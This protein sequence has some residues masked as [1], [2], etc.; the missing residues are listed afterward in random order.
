MAK[1]SIALLLMCLGALF[2]AP[3]LAQADTGNIIE[4]NTE[5][6]NAAN[7][8][9][10]ATCKTDEPV[11]GEPKIHCSPQT[12]GAFYTLA[13]GH[14]PIGFTQYIIKHKLGEGKVEPA[15]IPVPTAEIEDPA[16]DQSIKTLR[17]DLPPGLT[18]NPNATPKCSLAE[19]ENKV[20]EFHVPTCKEGTIV[21]R[22]EI[23][24]VTTVAGVPAPSPPF[25]A[26]NTLPKGFIIPP[27]ESSGTKVPVYNLQPKPG[28]PALFGFVA[29]G[30]EVVFLETEVSWQNDFHES[31]TINLPK[32]EP[33]FATLISRLVNFGQEAGDK[34]LVE[35]GNGTYINNPTTCFD[36]N[37]FPTLYSTWFRAHSYGEE[38]P[39]FPFGSTPFEA[40]VESSTGELIQQ[41]GCETVPFEPGIEV[42]PGTKEIDSPAGPTV[43][44]TLEYLTGEESEQQESHLRK[45]AET[46]PAGMGLNPS[47]AQGLKAC[48]DAQFKKGVRTYTNE[49]PAESKIGTV[50]IESP[51][52]E[53]PLEGDVY[54]GEQKSN[55]PQSGEE[56]RILVEAKEE[57]EG[58][59]VRLVG[60]TKANPS[61]G[62]LTAVFN[63][64]QVGE[65]AGKLPEGL[66]QVP[67][68]SVRIH[69]DQ[70]KAVLTSPPTCSPATTTGEMTPWARPEEVVKISSEPFT[71]STDPN[72]G[73]CPKT[74]AER[75]FAPSYKAN[76]DSAKGGSFSPF[77]VRIARTDGQQELKV[78]N[79][80]LPKGLTGKLAGI[81]Y[82]AEA[83]ITAAAANSGAAEKAKPS[84][85][86]ESRLGSV[87]TVS[88]TGANPLHLTGQAYLAGPYKGAPISLVTVTPAVAGPFDLGTVVVRVALNVNPETAQVNAVSDVIPDVFGGVK[89]DL[90]S[91]NLDID[92][93]Q[94]MVNPTNCAAQATTGAING[95]GADPTNPAVFS[96]YAVNDPFQATECNKLGFKPKLK[97]Q[98]FGPTTRAKNPRLKAVLTARGG[99]ANIVRTA[100]TTPH[101]LFLD[102]RHIGTVCT[103]PQLASHTCPAASVYGTA[104][105]KSPLLSG[106]LKGKVYLV[107]SNHKL[108][109]L[110]A[111]LRGQVEIYLRA[112]ISSKHGGLKTVFNNTPDVPVNKVVLNMKGGKKSLLRTSANIC[113]K[114]QR[115]VLNI[116]GQNGKKV[117][118]NKFKLNVASCKKHK[119]KKK[120]K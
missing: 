30:K 32:Q 98:L 33:P 69:F 107:S 20:G 78:V 19:F 95:G 62:Q 89:L 49:C 21:G 113:A 111:D 8:W 87:E 58:I 90:R 93:S 118:N 6:P 77:H 16:G 119:G 114:P 83:A 115:A 105:A 3:A 81:P 51:P 40:K 70:A 103:R 120:H 50:E 47:G 102:Q 79:V 2:V 88:G 65:L 91:I 34:G 9:Q 27:S 7:G 42:E 75:K 99:D 96:S 109:D 37:Q 31:F 12:P 54:V 59:D 1:R 94:F 18:V 108:P 52:L 44:T 72:G 45:A 11:G 48:T 101:S 43:N 71:L 10:A 68:T 4:P 56:F 46:L 13:G 117:K 5:P 84:C 97:V 14:P 67:F 116:K 38:D 17:V 104:E 76:T 39:T 74:M 73:S 53:R 80:T 29:A 36:P 110:L 28:E 86:T 26:G 100:L 55:D 64:Q 112:T 66:P 15:G 24:L 41:E 35:E 82:C 63:E 57:E 60:H 85:S 25:P 106:K 23:T 22:E 61:T 92:R